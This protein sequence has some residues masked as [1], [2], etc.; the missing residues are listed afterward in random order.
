MSAGNINA[1]GIL[2]IKRST[3]NAFAD[4]GKRTIRQ[5]GNLS[6]KKKTQGAVL[7]EN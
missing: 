4:T 5:L 6:G 7:L 3:A 2:K 1:S